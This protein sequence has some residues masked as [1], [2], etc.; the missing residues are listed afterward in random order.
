MA[1]SR[2][3]LKLSKVL[4]LLSLLHT[5]QFTGPAV[6]APQRPMLSLRRLEALSQLLNGPARDRPLVI[7]LDAALSLWERQAVLGVRGVQHAACIILT[8]GVPHRW[9]PHLHIHDSSTLHLVLFLSPR[10]HLLRPLWQIWRP[11]NLLLFSLQPRGGQDALN[12]ASLGV[13]KRLALVAGVEQ[14]GAAHP[15]PLG[16]YTVFPLRSAK[17]RLLALWQPHVFADWNT[18]FPDRFP[19][20][21][22]HALTVEAW[23]YEWP[24]LHQHDPEKEVSGIALTMIHHLSVALNFTYNL[25]WVEE[26]GKL[27]AAKPN[28]SWSSL[29]YHRHVNFSCISVFPDEHIF[30]DFD[31]TE[32]FWSEGYSAFLVRPR[33]VLGWMAPLLPFTG[34]VWLAVVVAAAA[35]VG[36][37]TLQDAVIGRRRPSVVASVLCVQRG[38]LGHSVPLQTTSMLL[39]VFVTCWYA[40]CFVLISAYT[41]NLVAILTKPAHPPLPRT[42]HQLAASHYRL[43][44]EDY[45]SE[46]PGRLRSSEDELY[47]TL[48]EKVDLFPSL[49]EVLRA[50]VEGTHVYV[51]TTAFSATLPKYKYKVHNYTRIQEELFPS[52]VVWIFPKHVPWKHKFDV[53]INRMV[54]AGL[55]RHWYTEES[56]KFKRWVH[57]N[58]TRELQQKDAR[59]PKEEQE[60]EEAKDEE[61][62]APLSFQ[63]LRTLFTL[64]AVSWVMGAA[65]MEGEARRRVCASPP[66][67]RRT[68]TDSGRSATPSHVQVCVHEG[69]RWEGFY[70]SPQDARTAIVTTT[71]TTTSVAATT[72]IITTAT[73]YRT[74]SHS[75]PNLT[76]KPSLSLARWRSSGGRSAASTR[77]SSRSP[78]PASSFAWAANL[79]P[80]GEDRRDYGGLYPSGREPRR[81]SAPSCDLLSAPDPEVALALVMSRRDSRKMQDLLVLEPQARGAALLKVPG[82]HSSS[83]SSSSPV[84]RTSP[85]LSP[86]A[87]SAPS[88]SQATRCP[89]EATSANVM[90]RP[91]DVS[92]SAGSHVKVQPISSLCA[93]EA[94]AHPGSATHPTGGQ[95]THATVHSPQGPMAALRH[96]HRDHFPSDDEAA[97]DSVTLVE[98]TL[99]P[100]SSRPEGCGGR[101]VAHTSPNTTTETVPRRNLVYRDDNIAYVVEGLYLGNITA[102]Y[103]Q[104]LLCR[105]D[106]QC[107]VDLSGTRPTQVPADKKSICPCT[108]PLTTPHHRSRSYACPSPKPC[109]W[110]R[111]PTPAWPLTLPFE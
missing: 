95:H 71:F 105:L 62:R 1:A 38:L 56:M 63:H 65:V 23:P 9:P 97:E 79:Y 39:K 14:Q 35:A 42:L 98:E 81:S 75:C 31:I 30:A 91:R 110:C 76:V 48:G 82:A 34:H 8:L 21:H 101:E 106:V 28:G 86:L 85:T 5:A 24:F 84:P 37:V 92:G 102:A 20:L 52:P 6:P 66:P 47:Y 93:G 68:S 27:V 10:P 55:I 111:H 73:L 51:D 22:G 25:T 18:L 103:S 57:N 13:V 3:A 4:L 26:E 88:P 107:V 53:T 89:H 46:L 33:P 78:R 69:T 54:E 90:V 70:S 61:K 64:I 94:H 59:N 15:A 43:G 32:R 108:C 80:Q 11:H 45:G 29:V 83:S 72:P 100:S 99:Q 50:M 2:P 104:P 36:L 41:T 109:P 44:I 16:V 19:S 96:T 77:C 17:P 60:E 40:F 87:A 58:R 12:D 74:P 7:H 49:V 67:S